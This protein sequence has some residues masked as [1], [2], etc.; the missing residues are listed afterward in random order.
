MNIEDKVIET[1]TREHGH[2]DDGVDGLVA[3]RGPDRRV[4][5]EVGDVAQRGHIVPGTGH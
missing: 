1:I 4:A 3:V 2:V 5:L